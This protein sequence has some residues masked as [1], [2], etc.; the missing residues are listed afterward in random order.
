MVAAAAMDELAARAIV[1]SDSVVVPSPVTATPTRLVAL[2]PDL[3]GV[4]ERWSEMM[5]AGVVPEAPPEPEPPP[6]VV[7]LQSRKAQRPVPPIMKDVTD[8]KKPSRAQGRR[9]LGKA[10]YEI[11]DGI[12]AY[13]TKEQVLV[14]LARRYKLTTTLDTVGTTIH[15]YAKERGR[16][17]DRLRVRG[18]N[19]YRFRPPKGQPIPPEPEEFE[20][21]V[22]VP[23]PEP[24]SEPPVVPVSAPEP[25]PEEMG[26]IFDK[27]LREVVRQAMPLEQLI[28]R[29]LSDFQIMMLDMISELR[30]DLKR[31]VKDHGK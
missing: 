29:E 20:P 12:E 30:A 21:I 9:G 26:A 7:H 17:Y 28:E 6:K 24:V 31:L 2:F 23:E 11:L 15:G 16:E 4:L 5:D 18:R 22:P 3:V 19:V 13:F 1:S 8:P 27:T 10:V 14:E 25:V